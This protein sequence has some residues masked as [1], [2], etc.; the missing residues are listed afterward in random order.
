MEELG[1]KD[2]VFK[3]EDHTMHPRT[4]RQAPISNT[5]KHDEMHLCHALLMAIS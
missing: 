4:D 5:I 2:I 1:T 3:D